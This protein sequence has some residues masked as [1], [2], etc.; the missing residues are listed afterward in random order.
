M[1]WTIAIISALV[2]VLGLVT[3]Y[4]LGGTIHVLL[5][6]AVVLFLIGTLK[7]GKMS[8]GPSGGGPPPPS[9]PTAGA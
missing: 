6:V 1:I 7:A 5:A 3:T 9:S 2:W 8:V 4:T